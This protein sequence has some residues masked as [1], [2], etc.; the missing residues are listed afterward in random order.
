MR[1]LILYVDDVVRSAVVRAEDGRRYTFALA[2]LPPGESVSSGVTVD[3]TVDAGRATGPRLV[4]PEMAGAADAPVDASPWA[5]QAPPSA[6][7]PEAASQPVVAPEAAPT[8]ATAPASEVVTATEP[9][10]AAEP[11]AVDAAVA[12]TATAPA[13]STEQPITQ[14]V[15]RVAETAPAP[16]P[17]PDVADGMSP[18]AAYRNLPSNAAIAAPSSPPA[19]ARAAMPPPLAAPPPAFGAAAAPE[20]AA[21]TLPGSAPSGSQLRSQLAGSPIPADD[22]VPD[23]SNRAVWL[24][25][26]GLLFAIVAAFGYMMMDNGFSADGAEEKKDGGAEVA[27]ATISR[28]L[29]RDANM[30]AE[31]RE[32]AAIVGQMGRGTEVRGIEIAGTGAGGGRW[33]RIDNTDRYLRMT[34]YGSIA[35]PTLIETFDL[36]MSADAITPVRDQ[37]AEASRT[38]ATLAVGQRYTLL[39]RTPT[40]WAEVSVDGG[41]IGYI[42]MTGDDWAAAGSTRGALG[43][44][45]LDGTSDGGDGLDAAGGGAGGKPGMT[46][47]GDGNFPGDPIDRPDNGPTVINDTPAPPVIRDRP[48]P[49]PVIRDRPQPRPVIRDRPTPQPR[50]QPRPRPRPSQDTPPVGGGYPGG[51]GGGDG[52]DTPPVGG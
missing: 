15:T 38:V 33:L 5:S 39:G 30:L 17:A 25:A 19:A 52:R 41:G 23:T 14:P 40:G 34:D 16:A 32:G 50:P 45:G 1:G 47:F 48:D 51:Y 20:P 27:T 12:D 26:G 10:I 29:L 43:G 31:P 22:D 18:P 4:A 49:R 28:Y 37:P 36:S 13:W 7:A 11:V 8:A 42:T 35:P 6:P 24:W 21:P 46:T 9:A 44:D 2:D 3:F